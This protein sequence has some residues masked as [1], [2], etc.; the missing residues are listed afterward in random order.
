MRGDELPRVWGSVI[1]RSKP[2]HLQARHARRV[3][4]PPSYTV[5]ETAEDD[6]VTLRVEAKSVDAGIV[7]DQ[8][9]V[10]RLRIAW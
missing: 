7:L 3:K 4:Q 8:A 1:G 6:V 5:A 2:A 9:E 10:A